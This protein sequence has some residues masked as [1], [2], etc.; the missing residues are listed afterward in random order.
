[1]RT[2]IAILLPL[3]LAGCDLTATA[4]ADQVC[5]TQPTTQ[6]IPGVPTP[7]GGASASV[8]VPTNISIDIGVAVPTD[9]NENGVTSEVIAQSITLTTAQA[10]DLSGVETLALTLSAAGRPDVAFR[11]ARPA[12]ATP[13]VTAI[14]A[15]PEVPVNFVDYLEGTDQ[16]RISS[17][18]VE[19]QPPAAAW[20]PTLRTCASAKVEVDELEAAGL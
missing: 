2:R 17:I 13:P 16:V 6:T 11:Y 1:M 7:P 4:E 8:T 5:V 20:T 19:G 12:G 18:S 15:T 10:V 3:A 14:T 9:L